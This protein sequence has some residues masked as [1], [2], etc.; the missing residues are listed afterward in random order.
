MVDRT[1][2]PGEPISA[3]NRKPVDLSNEDIVQLAAAIAGGGGGGNGGGGGGASNTTE[4]TQLLVLAE[5]QNLDTDVGAPA[6]AAAAADGTGNYSVI[7]GIKR[8]LLNWVTLLARTPTLDQ[9]NMAGSSPVVIASDQSTLPTGD[10]NGQGAVRY[11]TDTTPVAGGSFSQIM[12]LTATTF[13]ALT[14][15][16]ASGSLVGVSL[17]AGTLLVGPFTAYTLTSGAVAAY[18]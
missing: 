15:T 2:N 18:A 1:F 14:R 17:P 3:E 5:L 6:D 12:C 11:T 4:A 10:R 8:G 7:A 9:K 13:S 16:G